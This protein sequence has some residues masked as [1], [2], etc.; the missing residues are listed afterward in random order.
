MSYCNLSHGYL[1]WI[2]SLAQ[3]PNGTNLRNNNDDDNV[4][5]KTVKVIPF[6]V[7]VT[8]LIPSTMKGNLEKLQIPRKAPAEIQKA[9]IL[10][11]YLRNS[12]VLLVPIKQ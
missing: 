12:K 5:V 2:Y 7:S 11:R 8:C 6:V 4:A 3:D 9:V 10:D 1:Y